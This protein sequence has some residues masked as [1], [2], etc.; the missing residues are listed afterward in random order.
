MERNI[1][2]RKFKKKSGQVGKWFRISRF[3]KIGDAILQL[4]N[5]QTDYTETFHNGRNWR[6]YTIE[7]FYKGDNTYR[8]RIDRT[9]VKYYQSFEE[10]YNE[11]TQTEGSLQ[12]SEKSI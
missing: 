1:F 9:T 7:V 4:N 8:V 10:V 5:E 6:P 11:R 12:E 3:G 2:L